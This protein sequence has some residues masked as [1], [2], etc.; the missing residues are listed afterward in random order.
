MVINQEQSEKQR[1]IIKACSKFFFINNKNGT[2]R[3]DRRKI[4]SFLLETFSEPE[5]QEFINMTMDN[6]GWTP[7]MF[8]TWHKNIEGVKTLLRLN[9]DSEV[10]SSNQGIKINAL[11][12]AITVKNEEIALLLLR[13][14]PNL[15]NSVTSLGQTPLMLACESSLPRVVKYLVQS[16]DIDFD[17][18]DKNNLN[19]ED[20]C[21][22]A[23]T[24]FI[25]NKAEYVES[26]VNHALLSRII[27]KKEA[28][29]KKI[30]HKI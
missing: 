29:D 12:L 11:H 19:F 3:I 24:N 20:Y 27:N 17:R 18:K 25:H 7:L 16:D 30:N 9:A 21:K 4:K 23:K 15:L 26:I 1:D 6:S 2:A 14:N 10:L 13:Q 28:R 8:C 22:K 5:N